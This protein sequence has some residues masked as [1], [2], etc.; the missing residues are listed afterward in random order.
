MRIFAALVVLLL[1][2]LLIIFPDV[3]YNYG[4]SGG[5]SWT[6]SALSHWI[7]ILVLSTVG[8]ILLPFQMKKIYA[9]LLKITVVLAL[10]GGYFF[11]R[12][13]YQGDYK[14]ADREL[15]DA[16]NS[17]LTEVLAAK[18]GFEGVIC[19][20]SPGCPF[21]KIA[22]RYR[23]KEIKRRTNLGVGV[24]LAAK[25]SSAITA[26]SEETE[27]PELDYF[28]VENTDG[29]NQMSEG[30]YPTFLYIKNKKIVHKWSNDNLGYPA[31][32]W[33]ESGME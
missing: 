1:S 12:P 5:W 22:T 27:S 30:R 16:T 17:V 29:M 14:K 25:D 18:P 26:Y 33:I 9:T 13:I 7:G 24:F 23:L 8:V 3:L 28:L 11:V 20:A 4:I 21:C 32:D 31:L 2:L 15:N 6:F 19:I 10:L